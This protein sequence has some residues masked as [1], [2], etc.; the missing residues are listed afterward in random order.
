MPVSPGGL[1]AVTIYDPDTPG[2]GFRRRTVADIPPSPRSPAS[3]GNGTGS[4][5]S[6]GAYR[7]PHDA[8]VAH[9]IGTAPPAGHDPH[10][11]FFVLLAAAETPARQRRP[12]PRRHHRHAPRRPSRLRPPRCRPD[13]P[14]R[15]P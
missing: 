9:C 2:S 12:T 10:R 4:Q 1:F 15:R 6:E 8:R 3:A 11:C 14:E 7:L 13:G 5:L